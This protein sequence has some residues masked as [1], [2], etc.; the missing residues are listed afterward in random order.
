MSLLCPSPPHLPTPLA[1]AP[2]LCSPA[3]ARDL[4]RDDLIDVLTGNSGDAVN[5]L[6]DRFQLPL[7]QVGLMGGASVRRCHRSKGGQFPGMEITMALMNGLEDLAENEPDSVEIKKKANVKRLL[8]EGDEV[9]GVEY[10]FEGETLH[11]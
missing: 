5:W 8:K 2:L 3:Q 6:M 7:N 11:E 9:V 10:E 1:D 4:A